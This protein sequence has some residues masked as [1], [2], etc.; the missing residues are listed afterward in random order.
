MSKSVIYT[1]LTTSTPITNGSIIPL[2]SIVRRYGCNLD[3]NGNTIETCGCGYYKVTAVA[4]ISAESTTPIT[5]SLQEDGVQVIGASST[6]TVA[7]TSDETVLTVIGVVR[8][9]CDK[10][11]AL[12]FVLTGADATIDNMALIVE[13]L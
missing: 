5:V 9:K 7:G 3:L 10:S 8:N 12:S 6:I 13:K 11:S 4:T 1:A 2:G